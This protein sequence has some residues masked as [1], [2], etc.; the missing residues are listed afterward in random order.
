MRDATL[1]FRL[2]VYNAK[3]VDEGLYTCTT[4]KNLVMIIMISRSSLSKNLVMSIIM[5]IVMNEDEGLYTCTTSKN[6][7]HPGEYENFYICTT[8]HLI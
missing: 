1:E 8:L 5:K 3:P 7:C 6:F 4:P 2:S